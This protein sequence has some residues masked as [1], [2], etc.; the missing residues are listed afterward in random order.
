M[1]SKTI[2]IE[3]IFNGWVVDDFGITRERTR[4]KVVYTDRDKLLKAIGEMLPP[5]EE[6]EMFIENV[7]EEAK[8]DKKG[9]LG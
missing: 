1:M 4:T 3:P 9:W 8:K 6:Q 7:D 2:S 5:T